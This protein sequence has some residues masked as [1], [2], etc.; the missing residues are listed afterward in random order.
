[1]ILIKCQSKS[2]GE[3]WKFLPSAGGTPPHWES[4][5][6]KGGGRASGH[7]CWPGPLEEEEGG[8]MGG[9]SPSLLLVVLQQLETQQG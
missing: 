1:M 3:S 2:M 5:R 6:K 8:R 4:W 9:E 7:L